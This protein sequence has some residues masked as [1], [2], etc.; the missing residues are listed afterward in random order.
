MDFDGT[1][2]FLAAARPASVGRLAEFYAI[3]E[4][5]LKGL[6]AA[7]PPAGWDGVYEAQSK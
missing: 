1:A 6:R 2:T 3:F 7:P 5:R 4:A